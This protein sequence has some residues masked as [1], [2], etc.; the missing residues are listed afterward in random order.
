[1]LPTDNK[2]GDLF[3]GSKS[4][5]N[6]RRAAIYVRASSEHQQYS[7]K[8]QTDALIIY[9]DSKG[10]TV[11][12]TYSDDGKS[13]LD[14]KWR[15]GLQQ[16]IADVQEG[17]ADFDVVLVYD[18]SRWGRFQDNDAGAYYEYACRQSGIDV[19]YVIGH[20]KNDGSITDSIL[21][22]VDRY[23]S[24][25]YSYTLSIKVHLGSSRLIRM[26]YRQGGMAGYGLRRMMIDERGDPKL[27]LKYG[28][29]K[30]LQTD[31]VILV[32]G[33]QEEVETV[34]WIYQ[35]FV[36]DKLT[37]VQIAALLNQQDKKTDLGR[38][39]TRGS[40][41]GILTNEKYIGNNV[42]NRQSFKLKK[43][44]V[45]NPTEEW[46][47]K[48][49]AFVAIVTP[50]YFLAAQHIILER[51]RRFTNEEM[52]GRLKELYER[53]GQL[54]GIIIDEQEGDFPP[55]SAYAR[56]FGGLVAAYKLVGFDPGIDYSFQEVNR[57]LRKL[58]PQ[59]VEDVIRKIEE[60]GGSVHREVQHDL[61][62]VNDELTVSVVLARCQ[63]TEAGSLRWN[64]RLD[65]GL[66]PD[67]TIAIR[68]NAEN[69]AVLDYYL[70]PAIDVEDPSLRLAMDNHA[71]LDAY[72]FDDL[73]PFFIAT[74]RS[75]LPE[76]L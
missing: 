28:E 57:R 42:Y 9:A 55:S 67:I 35:K 46:V 25:N 47:R 63:R 62:I 6:K 61:L 70:L 17:R 75:A 12:R 50:A 27:E 44:R 23:S 22:A 1:M 40:V 32:L 7:T 16:L 73:Q 68:M 54:S 20:L 3:N 10:Y 19:H 48:D 4:N 53:E 13:G 26:G 39:W 69:N 49:G 11:V 31:R 33:P 18:I 58:H 41:H 8:N 5:D 51:S 34:R 24:G 2:N 38:E 56:R 66:R 36:D 64:I 52:L 37:E 29:R 72:R 45:K 43:K 59:Q 74:G 65:T 76:A 21:K 15:K 71:A 60:F 30:S 14:I